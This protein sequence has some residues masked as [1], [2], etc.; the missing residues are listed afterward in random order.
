LSEICAEPAMPT[1]ETVQRWIREDQNF[2]KDVVLALKA[3]IE[4]LSRDTIP[5][6]DD[7]VGDFVEKVR[8][9]GTVV[10]VFDRDNVT[11]SKLRCEIRRW[12]VDRLAE[13]TSSASGKSQ[14]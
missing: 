10:T 9:D 8:R 3:L 1:R 14:E 12:A 5:I 2:H 7:S 13:E 6:A 4:D 11:R